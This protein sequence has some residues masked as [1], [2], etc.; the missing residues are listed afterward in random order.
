MNVARIMAAC[1]AALAAL[2]I[3]GIALA[4]PALGSGALQVT[5]LATPSS[6]PSISGLD[7]VLLPTTVTPTVTVTPTMTVTPTATVTP[8]VAVTGTVPV[9]MTRGANEKIAEGIAKFF[10]VPISDVLKIRNEMGWGGVVKVFGLAEVSGKSVDDVLALRKTEGW[11]Q[12]AKSLGIK[13]GHWGGNLGQ[14]MSGHAIAPSPGETPPASS[15]DSSNSPSN[16]GK[17]N[18]KGKG[19]NGNGKGKGH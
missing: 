12:V 19:G 9:T 3:S 14:I 16:L 7:R 13:P 4:G 10:G 17:G 15:G 2:G 1:F 6:T 5:A 11:G 18:G 8:T